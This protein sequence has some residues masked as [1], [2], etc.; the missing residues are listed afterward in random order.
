MR[1]STLYTE[2]FHLVS[3]RNGDIISQISDSGYGIPGGAQDKIFQKFF[4]AENI[5]PIETD[6]NGLGLYLTKAI[7]ESSGG[8]IWLESNENKGSSFWFSSNQAAMP[9]KARYRSIGNLYPY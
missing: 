3:S 8:R 7:I 5:I 1:L 6:G 2:R 4:R 9:V